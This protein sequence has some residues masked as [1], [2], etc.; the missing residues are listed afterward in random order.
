MLLCSSIEFQCFSVAA[1]I[2]VFSSRRS[3]QDLRRK[4]LFCVL[5][6]SLILTSLSAFVR[7]TKG[8][9]AIPH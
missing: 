4:M 1:A 9:C 8:G 7:Q 3:Q 2:L 5:I 6:A